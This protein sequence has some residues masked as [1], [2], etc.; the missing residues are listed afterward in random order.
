MNATRRYGQ[1]MVS[2]LL[3]GVL[4]AFGCGKD[5]PGSATVTRD[6]EREAAQPKGTAKPLEKVTKIAPEA[7][8]PKETVKPLDLHGGR[9]GQEPTR[10]QSADKRKEEWRTSL[11]AFAKELVAVAAKAEIPNATE[12][13]QRI[14]SNTIF[15]N[16]AGEKIWVVFAQGFGKELHGELAKRFTGQIEWE[17]VVKSVK[18]DEKN[19]TYSINVMFPV[20]PGAPKAIEFPETVN[21]SIP[22]SKLPQDK[23]PA[24]GTKFAFRGELRKEKEDALF[25]PVFVLY[26]LGPNVGK[27]TVGVSVVNVEPTTSNR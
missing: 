21:L 14:R 11:S 17:G 22:T 3:T 7:A 18:A 26:G 23:L 10:E 9:T 12:Q 8:Q 16:A 24:E 13:S 1:Y 4:L 15:N 5:N 6:Q 25:E 19:K 27:V 20:Q 2:G